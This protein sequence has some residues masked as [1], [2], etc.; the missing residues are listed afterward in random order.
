MPFNKDSLEDTFDADGNPCKKVYFEFK[1][2]GSKTPFFADDRQTRKLR[3]EVKRSSDDY[4]DR[5]Q[6]AAGTSEEGWTAPVTKN[7]IA[8]EYKLD[9]FAIGGTKP[10]V[11]YNFKIVN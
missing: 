5:F 8:G 1:F 3:I 7:V 4:I 11:S 2:F 9:L 6:M 10:L